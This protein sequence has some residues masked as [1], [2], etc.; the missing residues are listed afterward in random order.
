MAE[1]T[2]LKRKTTTI[3]AIDIVGY[4]RM[5]SINEEG[6]VL[7]LKQYRRKIDQLI[8]RYGGR[9]FNTGGDSVMATFD[10]TVESVRCAIAIQDDLYIL[11]A[12]KVA[13]EQFIY[14][15]GVTV[16][17]VMVDGQDLL[18]DAVNIAARIEGACDPGNIFVSSNVMALVKGKLSYRFESKGKYSVK[19]ISEPIE[20][21]SLVRDNSLDGDGNG[22]QLPIENYTKVKSMRKVF[23]LDQRFA[24]IFLVFIAVIAFVLG[25][26]LLRTP[27]ISGMWIFVISVEET[28]YRPFEHL[29]ITYQAVLTQQGLEI[30][31]N[32]EKY[33]EQELGNDPY[34]Y[35]ASGKIPITIERNSYNYHW[36]KFQI[37]ITI[38]GAI[39]KNFIGP[40]KV[41][42]QIIEDGLL[43]ISTAYHSLIIENGIKM[44]GHFNSTAANSA[45]RSEWNIR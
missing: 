29:E 6:T 34:F 43:R 4:G 2:L 41:E 11:N 44:V 15:I 13:N 36:Q 24:P 18:G 8:D 28:E 17:D 5:M 45:G 22:S 39:V 35:S 3:M 32:G 20:T 27:S 14:R 9:I 38:T 23:V 42:L 25:M 33:S 37:P 19:N 16:G 7:T 26:E 31:G 40:D 30:Q 21:F 12:D 1:K 10:S